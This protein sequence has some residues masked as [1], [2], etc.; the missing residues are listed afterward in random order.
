MLMAV[1]FC[2]LCGSRIELRRVETNTRYVCRKCHSPFHVNKAGTAVV[3]EPPTIER[4]LA[5]S[6]QKLQETME[7]IPL[8]TILIGAVALLGAVIVGYMLFGPAEHLD[9][10]GEKAGHALAENDMSYLKSIAVPGTGD[11]VGR[12]FDVVYPR[13]VEARQRWHGGKQEVVESHVAQEDQARR[14]GAVMLSIH[15]AL[16]GG[17]DLSLANPSAATAAAD[18]PFDVD[19]EW[20]L[21]RWGRW[22]LDGRATL[23]KVQP[24][25]SK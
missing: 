23:A 13:L 19:T 15:P 17:L 10:A 18:S 20:T 12:W 9:R 4:E 25:Q 22:Q 21:S 14:K 8:K 2:P 5:E 7:R 24:T 11:D 16:A 6:K 3:G 1:L